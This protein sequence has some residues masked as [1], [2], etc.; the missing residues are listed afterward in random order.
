M[1]VSRPTS[2]YESPVTRT[3]TPL[4]ISHTTRSIP[5]SSLDESNTGMSLVTTSVVLVPSFEY[6]THDQGREVAHNI[7]KPDDQVEYTKVP[8]FWSSVGKGLRYLGTG[9]GFDDS[10]TDGNVDELKVSL[11][12]STQRRPCLVPAR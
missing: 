11:L 10:Y 8:I 5:T 4:E 2:I 6:F 12:D 3:S 7:T 1:E 9:A